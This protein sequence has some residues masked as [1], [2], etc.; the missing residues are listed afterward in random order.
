M[1]KYSFSHLGRFTSWND[2][3]VHVAGALSLVN[4]ELQRVIST[5]INANFLLLGGVIF[6]TLPRL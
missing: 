1:T 5:M 3:K 4:L 6:L 2:C